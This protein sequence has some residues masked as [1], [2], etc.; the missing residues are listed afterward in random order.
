MDRTLYITSC[1]IRMNMLKSILILYR[2]CKMYLTMSRTK[3][4]VGK[5]FN[6]KRVNAA[7]SPFF[8]YIQFL[9]ITNYLFC[10]YLLS[11][12]DTGQK[13]S[14]AINNQIFVQLVL[15]PSRCNKL[16]EPIV[17]TSA[18]P[19]VVTCDKAYVAIN[20]GESM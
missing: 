20:S 15:V 5:I 19:Y 10:H 11:L 13:I 17:G 6:A 14:K 18:K 3:Q 12:N 7:Y 1:K 8:N 4:R 2:S 16:T 9:N